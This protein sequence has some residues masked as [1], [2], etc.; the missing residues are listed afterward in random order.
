MGKKGK[1]SMEDLRNLDTNSWLAQVGIMIANEL[2][3]IHS[4]L[5][6]FKKNKK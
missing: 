4:V 2:H 5:L 3:K 1:Y 6:G